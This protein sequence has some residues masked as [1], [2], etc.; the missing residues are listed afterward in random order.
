MKLRKRLTKFSLHVSHFN[1]KAADIPNSISV[2]GTTSQI[3]RNIKLLGSRLQGHEDREILNWLTE[4]DYGSLHCSYLRRRQEGTGRWLLETSEYQD[5]LNK[6]KQTL[7]CRGIPG[8]GKTILTSIIVEDLDTQ[9]QND[10]SIG[11]AYI[12]FNFKEQ[13]KQNLEEILAS[14]LKQLCQSRSSLPDTM[15][16][17]YNKHK[18][19]RTRPLSDEVSR[20]LQSVAALY[21]RVFIAIDALDECKDADGCRSKLLSEICNLQAEAEASLFI[22]SRPI[23]DIET[24]F[25]RCL[26]REIIASKE[27]VC[28]YIDGHMS[29]LPVFVMNNPELQEQIKT[30]V[31]GAVQGM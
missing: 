18:D 19:K 20:S 2:V 17:L 1:P 4:T 9:F 28:R 7:F 6:S 26:S 14:L 5:W 27:D 12:Y 29:R 11:I 21:S 24:K 8:A 13:E 3:D 16:S 30:E 10:P 31:S 25:Q 22:T 23:P 15:V